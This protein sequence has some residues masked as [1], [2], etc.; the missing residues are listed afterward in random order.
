MSVGFLILMFGVGVC[1]GVLNAALGIGGGILMVPALRETIPGIDAHT[2]KGTS[3]FIIIFVAGLNAWRQNRGKEI[4]WRLI[5]ELAAGSILGGYAGA[6]FTGYLSGTTVTFNSG[7]AGK[8]VLI[9]GDRTNT[10]I[11][12]GGT[13]ANA[14]GALE[15]SFY[16]KTNQDKKVAFRFPECTA[17]KDLSL[18]ISEKAAELPI[19]FSVGTPSGWAKPYKILLEK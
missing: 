5:I 16:A 9:G 14:L 6:R 12:L 13:T 15:V 17:K 1:V 11:E 4:P 7:D 3:L 2:A 10:M 19:S 8:E 18:L